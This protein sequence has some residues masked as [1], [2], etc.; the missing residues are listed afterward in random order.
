MESRGHP[1]HRL[2]PNSG[3]VYPLCC[4]MFG[5]LETWLSFEGHLPREAKLPDRPPGSSILQ[6]QLG[7]LRQPPLTLAPFLRQQHTQSQWLS[8]SLHLPYSILRTGVYHGYP[9][10]VPDLR[11]FRPIYIVTRI[12]PTTLDAVSTHA[13]RARHT[14]RTIRRRALSATAASRIGHRSSPIR[15]RDF[16]HKSPRSE[17]STKVHFADS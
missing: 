2:T 16:L 3:A 12:R 9:T 13:F 4:P 10:P 1:N 14:P 8:G 11:T 5:V 15:F 7:K 17:L 6:V